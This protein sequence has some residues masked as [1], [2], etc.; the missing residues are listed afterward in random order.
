[1]S[2]ITPFGVKNKI[3]GE[4]ITVPCGKCPMCLKRRISGWSFRLMQETKVSDSALF[5]TLTYDTKNM[6]ITKN[7][8]MTLK[9]EDIQLFFKRLRKAHEKIE[10]QKPIKY[11]CA[12]E[13]GG[14]TLRPHW[15][16]IL[17]NANIN[18][19]SKAWNLG[20]IHFGDVNEASVGYSL[21]Y[22]C[23]KG[24]IPMHQNDD[25]LKE[26]SL[27]SKGLGKVY[28]TK[29]MVKW[30]KNDLENRM[31]CNLKDGKKIAMPRYY[32]DKIYNEMERKRAA[33]FTRIK[34]IEKQNN[35]IEKNPNYYADLANSHI[36]IIEKFNYQ[37][38]NQREKI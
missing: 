12:G 29:N 30:H 26:R 3:S 18:L 9:K 34:M 33:F 1:M 35:E 11:Y 36:A 7:G 4:T 16:I 2:C 27:M 13:Y 24:K 5:L 23:K 38:K 15:H 6:P 22:I 17:F 28:I 8:F 31:Y 25:R 21:K 10:D 14:K 32:K 37:T 20:H 19:V